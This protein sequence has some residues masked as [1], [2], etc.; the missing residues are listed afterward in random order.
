MPKAKTFLPSSSL[1]I[2]KKRFTQVFIFK[3]RYIFAKQ[4]YYPFWS[5][6]SQKLM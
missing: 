6:F 2:T 3:G 1:G 4:G 5:E